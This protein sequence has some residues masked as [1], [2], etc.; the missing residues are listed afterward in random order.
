MIKF[1]EDLNIRIQLV[2]SLVKHLND[3]LIQYTS[4]NNYV[5]LFKDEKV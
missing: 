2:S 5:D 3:Q 1:E 4:S